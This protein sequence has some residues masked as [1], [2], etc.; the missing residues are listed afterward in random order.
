MDYKKGRWGKN[1]C[2]DKLI[3]LGISNT[4]ILCGAQDGTLQIFKEEVLKTF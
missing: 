4:D 2:S 3:T 1:Q